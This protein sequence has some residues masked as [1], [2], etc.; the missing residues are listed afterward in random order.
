M[1]RNIRRQTYR[2]TVRAV[3]EKVRVSRRKYHGLHS[4]IVEV[5]IEI[6]GFFVDFAEH[7][8]SH[9]AHSRL[10]VP[11]RCGGIAVDGTEVSVSVNERN[12]YREVLSEPYQ[13][14]VYRT[15]AVRVVFTQ[16]V[17][18]YRSAFLI[19]F[20]GRKTEFVHRIKYSSVNGFKS[21]SYVGNRSR[22]VYAHRVVYETL[23]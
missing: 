14:V 10:G 8:E 12:V 11:V 19:R 6:D 20:I 2:Y 23:L 7:F 4:R 18:D 17:S 21:V 3:Y 13:S 5:R 9:F 22:T 15:V 1:R 16:N